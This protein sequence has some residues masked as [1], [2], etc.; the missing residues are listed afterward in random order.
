MNM[1][2][3][4]MRRDLREYSFDIVMKSLQLLLLGIKQT[5]KAF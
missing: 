4:S 3:N 2:A 1:F 5:D